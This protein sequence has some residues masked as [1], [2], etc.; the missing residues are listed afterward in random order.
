MLFPP[1]DAQLNAGKMQ[2]NTSNMS[3]KSTALRA[4]ILIPPTSSNGAIRSG[5][6]VVTGAL[7]VAR[8]APT[9]CRGV[10]VGDYPASRALVPTL[11]PPAGVRG[12]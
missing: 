9:W 3:M 5:L 6:V 4:W 8:R 2:A 12:R 1:F 7:P 11:C 10:T